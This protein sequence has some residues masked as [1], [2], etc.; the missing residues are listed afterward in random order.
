LDARLHIAKDGV[1]TV[2]TGKVEAGQGARAEITQAAAEELRAPISQIRLIMADSELCPDDGPTYG[3]MTTPRTLPMIRSDC[4]AA[5]HVLIALAAR[6]WNL[7]A[8]G[9][10]LRDGVAIDVSGRRKLTYGD[11]ASS[12]DLFKGP[13]PPNVLVSPVS[14]W[15][16]MGIP[17]PRPNAH[18]LVNGAYRYP[19]AIAR[20]GMLHGKVLRAPAYGAKLRSVDVSAAKSMSGV[21][22]IQDGDFVGVAAPT[23]HQAKKAVESIAKTAQWDRAPHHS[24]QDL[25]KYLRENTRGGMPANPFIDDVRSAAKTLKAS[26]DVAYAQHAPM[27][28]RAAVAE[29]NDGRVTVWTA[30][31]VPAGVKGEL[32][33]ALRI[34]ADKV[35]VIIPDFGGAF[36]GKHTGEC[37]VEA[38][39]L[40][41]A[42][43]KP[44]SLCW[45]R[46]EEFTWAA[47]RS[48][49]AIDIEA[50]LDAKG[51]ITSWYHVAIQGAN[52]AP[53]TPYRVAHARS[54]NPTSDQPLRLAAYRA[55]GSTANMFARESFM[56]ELAAAAGKD[57]LEFRLAHL[58][59]PRLRAV[60]E[61][62]AKRFDWASRSARRQPN[63][64]V[65]LACGTEKGS[66]VAACVEVAVDPQDKRIRIRRVCETFECGAIVNPTNLLSQ[67]QGAIIQGIGP[68]LREA[69]EFKDGVMLNP[70]FSTYKV[71]RFVDLPELEINLLNR[72]DLPPV[73]AGETPL[74]ALAP[75]VANAVYAATATRVRHMPIKL[76]RA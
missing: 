45:T 39:R 29:W 75:A 52:A 59:D 36:G 15:K 71:P 47:F 22:V 41:K 72:P 74:I 76:T 34:S 64:G 67:V 55:L 24:S 31:Q 5:R 57:R 61:D 14:D 65:G 53:D 2:M 66:F 3:S 13:I 7:T 43:R 1:I 48:A 49:A 38:A 18:D 21:V 32:A 68:A 51:T 16:V 63:I 25:P 62:A 44:V 54:V 27:E 19:S 9:V 20:P 35:R 69:M 28:P 33:T 11:L 23:T 30:S 50:T 17:T 10:T 60:L 56:D 73:G 58:D 70:S 12:D 40:S 37:A 26:Y 6:Q 42:A 46:E 4:A 8:D